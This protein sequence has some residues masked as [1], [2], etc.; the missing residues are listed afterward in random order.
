MRHGTTTG[1]SHHRCRCDACRAAHTAH[2]RKTTGRPC[3]RCGGPK[4]GGGGRRLCEQCATA[5]CA[6]ESCGRPIC[7]R[8]LCTTHYTRWKRYGDPT[9]TRYDDPDY[10]I[11]RTKRP[12]A[13]RF[14]EKVDFE[15]LCWEWLGGK[16]TWGYGTFTDEERRSIGAHRWAYQALVGPIPDGL[17]LDHLCCNPSCVNPAHLEPVT[18]S[19]NLSR[20]HRRAKAS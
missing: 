20:R 4:A 13:E 15:G 6:V 9:Y 19:E 14:W 2:A 5:S 17:T 16:D 12:E 1:Y 3:V 18:A 8:G 7:H 10:K 11:P